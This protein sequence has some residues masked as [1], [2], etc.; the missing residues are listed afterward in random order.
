M[1]AGEVNIEEIISLNR[2]GFFILKE[3]AKDDE[4][5][6]FRRIK[7]PFLSTQLINMGVHENC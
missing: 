1:N 5:G 6:R 4:C 3:N 7:I 2:H